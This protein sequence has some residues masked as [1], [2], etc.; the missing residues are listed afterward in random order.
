MYVIT[1]LPKGNRSTQRLQASDI[2]NGKEPESSTRKNTG[3]LGRKEREKGKQILRFDKGRHTH[4]ISDP[5]GSHMS[6]LDH[7]RASEELLR[8]CVCKLPDTLP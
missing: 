4:Y 2:V 6:V 5:E 8:A 3:E 7:V 1:P